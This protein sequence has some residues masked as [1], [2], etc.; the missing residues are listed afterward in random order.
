MGI[1]SWA[2][3]P[4]ASWLG[5]ASGWPQPLR[6]RCPRQRVCQRRSLLILITV[7]W[8]TAERGA[9]T[10]VAWQGM[11]GLPSNRQHICISTEQKNALR[12]TVANN[13]LSNMREEYIC[14]EWLI[15]MPAEDDK[16]AV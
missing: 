15:D 14:T 12:Q 6:D 10:G 7:N 4:G 3:G 16:V 9:E 5:P 13:W 8:L 2:G 11:P 1:H